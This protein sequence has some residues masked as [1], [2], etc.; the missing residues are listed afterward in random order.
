MGQKRWT[1]RNHL[2]INELEKERDEKK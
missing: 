1:R 2:G